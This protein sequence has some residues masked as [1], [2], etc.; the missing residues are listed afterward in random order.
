MGISGEEGLQAASASDYSVA[1]FR[2]LHRLLF[3][4]GAWNFDRSVKVE[5][6]CKGNK[7]FE[8]VLL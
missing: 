3:V 5:C 6:F 8:E 1:Q 7:E 2:F 4:H